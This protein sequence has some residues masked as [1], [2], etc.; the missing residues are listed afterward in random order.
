[1]EQLKLK[2][3]RL[4]NEDNFGKER[5]S[6]F[7]NGMIL[8]LIIL[9]FLQII[10]EANEGLAAYAAVFEAFEVF[11]I[12]VFTV[13]YLIRFWV[14]GVLDESYTGVKGR[15]RYFISF[16]T[17][18]DFVVILPFYWSLLFGGVTL[19]VITV[20]RVL[21]ILRLI[22]YFKS[23]DFILKAVQNKKAELLISLGMVLILLVVA[24]TIMFHL[25]NQAQPDAFSSIP[26]T[27]WWGVATLTTVGYGDIYPIT[28]FGKF[29][30]GIMAI[31]G[32]GLFALPAG[33]IAS[34]FVEEIEKAKKLKLLLEE[35]LKIK[36]A[37]FVEYFVPVMNKKKA[38]GLTSI[39][40]KWL[41][42]NDIKY[43]M[44][45]Q[46]S[47]V[48]DVVRFSKLFRL[49]NVKLS[50]VDKAGLEYIDCNRSYGQY[51]DRQSK[52]TIVNLYASIQPYFGHFSMVLAE[53]LGANYISNE[54]YTKLSFLKDKQLN[55]IVNPDYTGD[56]TIEHPALE[57]LIQDYKASM[58]AD[59]T[60]IFMVNAAS[61][62]TMF[63]FNTAL[64]KGTST[65]E[66]SPFFGDTDRLQQ[67]FDAAGEMAKN[68]EMEVIKQKKNGTPEEDHASWFIRKETKADV[69]NLHVN[70]SLLKK[71][72]VNYYQYI[73]ELADCLDGLK[74]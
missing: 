22:R 60:C 13:E 7:F 20:I 64:P 10:L 41:S 52:L 15:I 18:V 45:I 3:A 61:N 66:G 23:F 33:I 39:P 71:K 1:M 27:M 51:I 19:G 5:G 57:E 32:V 11:T 68:Y 42:L 28:G 44:G 25:E 46:E 24:S 63:Q 67:A 34:G 30:G 26:A 47:T 74:G 40:R 50:G 37:F 65:F 35:E 54:Q 55:T 2:F 53:I 9:S 17:V 49:R 59:S 6:T 14:A 73:K 48:L 62:E 31:L 29:L 12:L 58:G 69:V 72:A 4:V 36:H 38:L 21:R 8:G 56:G 43:K 70:V 16:Y